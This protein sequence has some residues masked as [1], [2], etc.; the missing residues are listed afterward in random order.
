ME[1]T[2]ES[3]T[4]N[5]ANYIQMVSDD[6]LS[7]PAKP[8]DLPEKPIVVA[9]LLLYDKKGKALEYLVTHNHI[10]INRASAEFTKTKLKRP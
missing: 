5:E 3:G 6:D 9:E 4:N 7:S 1:D 10:L 2:F 8:T